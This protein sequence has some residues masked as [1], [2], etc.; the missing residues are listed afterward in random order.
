MVS[1]QIEEQIRE[2]FGRVVYSHKTH[3]KCADLLD[4]RLRRIKLGQ[5]LLAA[6]TTG[7]LITVLFGEPHTSHFAALV[8][9]VFSTML[10]GL[11]AYSKD[12]EPGRISQEHRVAAGKLWNVRES[13]LSLLA[14][15]KSGAMSEDEARNRRDELQAKLA[16]VYETAPR[17][18]AKG[19][20]AAR[21]ALKLKEDLTFSDAEI[22]QFLPEHL[23]KP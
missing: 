23:K 3:E 16:S 8:S 17:T 22:N 12:F 15:T 2:C 7:G 11:N 1:P 19:Y 9:A 4:E 14:D 21:D 18:F 10:L 13:Y 6:I 20:E 5:L